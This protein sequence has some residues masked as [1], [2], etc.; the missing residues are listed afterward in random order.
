MPRLTLKIIE[1]N[2]LMFDHESIIELYPPILFMFQDLRM[3][4]LSLFLNLLA[5]DCK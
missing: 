4:L 1:F 5:R 2:F 3:S